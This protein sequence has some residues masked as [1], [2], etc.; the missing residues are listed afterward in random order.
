M[1]CDPLQSEFSDSLSFRKGK[2]PSGSNPPP[3]PRRTASGTEKK[4]G[5]S[6]ILRQQTEPISGDL[7]SNA[8]QA[9]P[10]PKGLVQVL[11]PRR[12]HSM[13]LSVKSTTQ[14]A[15]IR[16]KEVLLN[17]VTQLLPP[18]DRSVSLPPL[19]KIRSVFRQRSL[20]LRDVFVI[21]PV[22]ESSLL[23]DSEDCKCDNPDR[24]QKEVPEE[25][26]FCRICLLELHEGGETLKM[27]CSC[28][29]EMALAH[30]DCAVKWFGIK[31]D[32]ICDICNSHVQNLPVVLFRCSPSLHWG[33]EDE[34]E[35]LDIE[36]NS[37]WHHAAVIVLSHVLASL[38]QKLEELA[39]FP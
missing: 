1:E 20:Q 35:D 26:A 29:G 8:E 4:Q 9:P 25:E 16:C 39:E 21:Q 23:A 6:S 36:E 24:D 31:G 28:K 3:K 18:V 19:R 14:P 12:T 2:M 30:K 17:Q 34:M 33:V 37:S 5:I 15:P 22:R 10:F 7:A 32:S 38:W 13:P 11:P 27:E